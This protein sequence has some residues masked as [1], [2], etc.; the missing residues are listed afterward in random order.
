MF[1]SGSI[2]GSGWQV[3][4]DGEALG[5]TYADSNKGL[6]HILAAPGSPRVVLGEPASASI[7]GIVR[8]A[9]S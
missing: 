6:R 1:L 3:L 9:N 2:W 5:V 7:P 4:Q 8:N